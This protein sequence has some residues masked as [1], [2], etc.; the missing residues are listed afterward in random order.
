[1]ELELTI[2]SYELDLLIKTVDNAD[3]IKIR[4]HHKEKDMFKV[5]LRVDSLDALFRLGL[6]IG[7]K[8]LDVLP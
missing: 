1:M 5:T 3:I 7:A 2:S 6:K 8:I 4:L